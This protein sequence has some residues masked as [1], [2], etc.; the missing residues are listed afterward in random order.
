[1]VPK[2]IDRIYWDAVQLAS[3]AERNAYLD[4][5][6]A[7][8]RELRGR[9]EQLLQAR[10]KA[11]GFLESPPPAPVATVDEHPLSEGPGTVIGPYKLL[12]QIGEG[13]FG[14]VFM[15]EQQEPLRRKVALKV[16]KPGMDSK[17][18][19]A[20]FEAER[21][22]LA[23]M[24]HPHIAKVLDAGQTSGGRPY[25]VMELVKGLPITDY[26]DQSRLTPRQRL[27][28]F[29]NVCQ[30]VQHAHQKG[31]IHRD[32]KPSNVLVTVQDGCALVKV[33]DFGIAKALGPQLT[34]KTLF[35]GFAQLVGTPLYMAPEQAALSN[36]DVDTR[37]DV[38][39]LGALLY[40]LLTGTT[41]FDK[42]RLRDV[43]YDEML[44]IIREEEPPRPSTR[45]ST[46][47]QAA[48]TVCSN[49][50]SDPKRLSQLLRGELDW[51]VMK[52]LEKDR[53]RRYETAN[54]FAMDVRRYLTDEPVLACPPSASYRFRKFARR[55]K[56]GLAI[57]GLV[58]S[59][60]VL[61]GS[62]IGWML[63]DRA[64]RQTEA[65]REAERAVTEAIRLR[66]EEKWPEALSAIR[67]AE[68][69]LAGVG[70]NP[71]LRQQVEQLARD[72]EMAQ[73][74][75]E[76]RLKLAACKEGHFDWEGSSAAY[77][78]AFA[79]YGLD[80]DGLDPQEAGER[81]RSSSIRMELAAAL[82]DWAWLRRG[83]R[84]GGWQQQLAVARAADP[85]PWRGRLRD[86]LEKEDPRAL[87]QIAAAVSSDELPPA[88]A[89]LLARLAFGTPAAGR[90]AEVLRQVRQRHPAD[91]WVNHELGRLCAHGLRPPRLEEA[92]RY[93]TAAVAIRPQSPA[94]RLNLA[95]ALNTHGQRDGA[96]AEC[97]EVLR[98]DAEYVGA[99]SA[100]SAIFRGK[101]L[102]DE[103]IA[104]ARE[105]LRIKKD[106]P[107]GHVDLGLALHDKGQLDEAVAEFREAIR[108]DKHNPWAHHNLGRAL[109]DKGQLDEA[110]AEAREALRIKENNPLLADGI[111]LTHHALGI[112]LADKGL[113]SEAMAEFR[114][115]IRMNNDY[116][117][118]HTGLGAAL[119]K[120][121]LLDDAIAEYREALRVNKE[122][123]TAH[124]NLGVALFQK[125]WLDEA[126]A[127][128]REALRLKKDY[129]NAHNNLGAALVDKGLLDEAI[130]EFRE[131][132]RI[133][134][135]HAGAHYNLGRVLHQKRQ[136]DEAIAEYRQ[137]LRID[138]G[139][140]NPHYNRVGR[141]PGRGDA[142]RLEKGCAD[143][144]FNLGQALADKGLPDE[145]MAAYRDAIHFKNDY[146]EA[147]CNLGL[148]L[149]QQGRFSEALA[150]LRRGHELG[151][152]NPGWSNPS[153]Q[154]LKQCER[155]LE[156]D[157]KLPT[158][159][160][161]GATLSKAEQ[162]EFGQLCTV[163]RW[164]AT[165]AGFYAKV[166]A[167][168]S[169]GTHLVGIR[170]AALAGCGKGADASK[171]NEAQRTRWRRQALD[172]LQ[173]D[174]AVWKK[175][176]ESPSPEARAQARQALRGWLHN[177]DLVG[178]REPEDLK[179]LPEAERDNWRQFWAEVAMVLQ[180]AQDK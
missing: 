156:L 12:E 149:Q 20:R 145:A 170:A 144:H 151:V 147:H 46:L 22:A 159:L 98:L 103:A 164:H 111:H 39:S 23:L 36:V 137:A 1:M 35:T 5:V 53:D 78:E 165:A 152:K 13:G 102:L 179:H 43:G 136:L 61:L 79:W 133:N 139:C 157:A 51:I 15:A 112:V 90:A 19:I 45:L 49:R 160:Q 97:R 29:A 40:E 167:E 127:E 129:D 93:Y 162:L 150:E 67:H 143:A 178:V 52:A 68:A 24:D 104:E 135:D 91:F 70:A 25:F 168:Q 71:G 148:G 166:Y 175:V 37:S 65:E 94:A 54:G 172:W 17:Q 96:L 119:W 108:I 88:T 38:Y 117:E 8:E 92:I 83:L 73:R 131:V 75:Q 169:G 7:G 173:A 141:Q 48:T 11:E 66:Q 154:W 163:K 80:L 64:A 16:L 84:S 146:A 27:E 32:L 100:L 122:S 118:A 28:L 87:D 3:A 6:C 86:A 140:A 95:F 59:F 58:L 171:L 132:T 50:Q 153:A 106:F 56:T 113:L 110:L 30:A 115:A 128:Y 125:G 34:D 89:V 180:T 47:G 134:K 60:V 174:F 72:L 99:H 14:V 101:G 18:V 105:A 2:S 41:P 176:L 126:V 161:E 109:R 4:R 85:D 10:S 31:V 142:R 33:I 42:E 63:R 114:Q 76:A 158:A 57:A 82:D 138:K 123:A 121:G 26:C 74:L 77:G 120:K 124:N 130:A 62:G 21:Q 81:L 155:W 116:G 55:N 107:D 69:A 177:L 9:V 44:R